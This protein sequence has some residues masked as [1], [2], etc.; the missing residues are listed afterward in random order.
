MFFYFG[1]YYIKLT[2][3]FPYRIYDFLRTELSAQNSL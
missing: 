3:M 1:Y 2:F